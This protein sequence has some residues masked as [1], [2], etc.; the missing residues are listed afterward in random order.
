MIDMRLQPPYLPQ[1]TIPF[2]IAVEKLGE[3]GVECEYDMVSPE[4][5]D[6]VQGI[7]FSDFMTH[8]LDDSESY[9]WIGNDNKIIDGH[10]RWNKALSTS[11]PTINVIRVGL[12][13][14]D[15]SRALNRVQD[16]Y[17]Y[18]EKIKS[19]TDVVGYDENEEEIVYD[20]LEELER[21]DLIDEDKRNTTKI[22]AYR[23]DDINENSVIGNFFTLTPSD[24]FQKYE[25]DFD[26]LLVVDDMGVQFLNSQNPIDVLVKVWFPTVNFEE[27][28]KQY[29]TTSQNLKTK[30]IA[31]KAKKMGYDGIR[32]NNN[33]I[34]GL[35]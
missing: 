2:S 33:L 13:S 24:D 11:K 5:L 9:V 32:Y 31:E 28:S 1:L 20:F 34:Q 26:N 23:K 18:D 27:K 12:N 3:N 10:H 14:R 19:E 4:D 8:D 22:I 25:I 30:A 17:E 7:T 21:V 29:N 6:P 15:A 35:K 16:I